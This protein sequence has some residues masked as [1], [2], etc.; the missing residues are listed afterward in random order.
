MPPR[1][2]EPES[3]SAAPQLFSDAANERA[4]EVRQVTRRRK[5]INLDRHSRSAV[6]REKI[7]IYGL[8]L[9]CDLSLVAVTVNGIMW[10]GTDTVG[11][12]KPSFK[13][14]TILLVIAQRR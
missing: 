5:P 10:I 2:T 4:E 13:Y 3:D 11:D 14:S 8:L 9:R 6:Y 7:I 12:R 1:V